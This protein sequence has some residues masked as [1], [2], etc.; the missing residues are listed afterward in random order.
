LFGIGKKKLPGNQ[1]KIA[2]NP[3]IKAAVLN[4]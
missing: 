1:R 4:L 3:E 2:E